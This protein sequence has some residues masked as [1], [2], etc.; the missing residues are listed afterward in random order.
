MTAPGSGAATGL[1]SLSVVMSCRNAAATLGATLESLV[2]QVYPGWWEVVVVDNASTDDTVGVAEAFTGRLPR[3]RIVRVEQP[4]HQGSGLNHGIAASEGEAVVFMDGDDLAAPD[5]LLHMGRALASAAFVGGRLD[6]ERL[7]P[8]S[9]RS[10][11]RPIQHDHVEVFSGYLPGV[12][13]A[14]M[15]VRRAALADV[16]GFDVSLPTQCDVDISWRLVGVGHVPVFVPD[17][18]LHYRYRRAAR[19]IF[20][21]EYGYGL[22]EALLHRKY[23]GR[24]LQRRPLTQVG[25]SYAR[26]LAACLLV[27]RPGGRQRL[28][29]QAGMVLG[30]L[31]G[32]LRTR[33]PAL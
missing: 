27:R 13:G 28:A 4:G 17:A 9:V 7:N 14:S 1:P 8:P 33:T 23:A 19:E 26:L 18:V 11:R 30:R 25:A 20:S 16:D 12:V 32:S 21:Q 5:Y 24:G 3:L 15:G 10:R 29:T 22:G 6:L 2:T 31:V